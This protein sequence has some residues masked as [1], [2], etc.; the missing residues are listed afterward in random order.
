VAAGRAELTGAGATARGTGVILAG[1]A[2]TRFGAPKGLELVGG[3]RIVDRVAS[4]L[5]QATDGL[6]CVANDPAAT[7]WLPGVEC[8]PDVLPGG[9]P[10]SGVHAALAHTGGAVVV[11]GW[12]MPFVEASLLSEL[13]RRGAATGADAC[14]P[15]S[16]SPVGMEPFCAW[17]AQTCLEP[18]AAA[19]REGNGGG[20]RFVHALARVAWLSRVECAGFG[21]VGRIFFNVNT[22][23]DLERAQA[24]ATAIRS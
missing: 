6:L 10:L 18:M 7:G 16:D 8:V 12:D 2:S 19:L 11:V 9:G 13:V 14:V 21:D 1:G 15:E 20:A 3:V 17:Y 24:M 22:A 23:A 5:R 4:A